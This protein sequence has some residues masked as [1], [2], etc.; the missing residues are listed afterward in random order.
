MSISV[1]K[2]R[3]ALTAIHEQNRNLTVWCLDQTISEQFHEY[4]EAEVCLSLKVILILFSIIDYKAKGW[5]KS[6]RMSLP[7]VITKHISQL[8]ESH[9]KSYELETFAIGRIII[10]YYNTIST[11]TMSS[12]QT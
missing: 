9:P 8:K 5:W 11:S 12:T 1:E 10:H 4:I 7:N 2:S 3:T 6:A